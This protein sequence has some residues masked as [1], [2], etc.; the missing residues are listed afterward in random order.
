MAEPQTKARGGRGRPP[1]D[2]RRGGWAQEDGSPGKTFPFVLEHLN[3]A[4]GAGPRT[5]R[6]PI[7]A[8]R[9]APRP[10]PGGAPGRPP[11]DVRNLPGRARCLLEPFLRAPPCCFVQRTFHVSPGCSRLDF[12]PRAGG[13][14]RTVFN[15]RRPEDAVPCK[16][17]GF[18][19]PAFHGVARCQ[20]RGPYGI[21]S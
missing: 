1:V 8:A 2:P 14:Y 15:V 18:P 13:I 5:K 19:P 7:P 9:P 17:C 3:V 6:Q 20:P 4:F 10:G 11:R 21:T 12:G 16:A